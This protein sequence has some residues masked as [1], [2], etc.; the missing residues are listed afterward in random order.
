MA[1]VV[2]HASEFLQHEVLLSPILPANPSHHPFAPP[3]TLAG[4]GLRPPVAFTHRFFILNPPT[5]STSLQ[6]RFVPLSLII[7]YLHLLHDDTAIKQR[8][9]WFLFL[10]LRRK[11]LNVTF[12]KLIVWRKA[13]SFHAALRFAIFTRNVR[14]VYLHLGSFHLYKLLQFYFPF[15]FIW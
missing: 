7:A 3:L 2:F 6:L 4:C 15:I 9:R 11:T 13:D 10:C 8:P 14:V 1:R 5:A 12:A